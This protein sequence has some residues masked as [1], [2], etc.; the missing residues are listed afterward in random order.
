MSLDATATTGR[1]PRR[2]PRLTLAG[3]LAVVALVLVGCG[4]T[5][6]GLIPSSLS[7]P[8]RADVDA[9]EQAA[10][11]GAGSCHDTE[12]ALLKLDQDFAA[13]P[14]SVN[15]GLRDSL[16]VGIANLRTRALAICAQ[17]VQK[18]TSTNT[19]TSKTPPPTETQTT[20]T[21]TT[22]E[23]PPTSTSTTPA[24]ETTAPGGGTEAGE[25]EKPEEQ[26]GGAAPGTGGVGNGQEGVK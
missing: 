7:E 6:K 10:E 9:V 2:P 1:R 14:A 16:R 22:A 12:S 25:A 26:T 5:G 3:C 23:P 4:G 13:L 21:Q 18:T 19:Q 20:E 8:L 11:T 24:E 15:S 17:P